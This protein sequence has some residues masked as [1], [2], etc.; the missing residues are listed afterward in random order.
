MVVAY[1]AVL[2][3]SGI[4][5]LAAWGSGGFSSAAGPTAAPVRADVTPFGSTA[6]TA[7]GNLSIPLAQGASTLSAGTHVVATYQFQVVSW[8][9]GLTNLTVWVAS[10][11]VNFPEASGG[12]LTETLPALNETVTSTALSNANATVGN[13]TIGSGG[14]SFASGSTATLSSQLIAVMV[15][16][17]WG[18]VKL[19][20]RWHWES[21]PTA[22]TASYSPWSAYQT[23][24]PPEH[25]IV[26][27]DGP[28]QISPGQSFN[29]CIGGPIQS[30]SFSLHM[31]VAN[32]YYAFAW[33]STHVAANW[34]GPYCWAVLMPKSF[35][36]LPAALLVHLWEYNTYPSILAILHTEGVVFN[37]GTATGK[38]FPTSAKAQLG[39]TALSL[40]AG[41]YN[42]DVAPGTYS[43]TANASGYIA[44]KVSVKVVANKTTWTNLTL[45]PADGT[46]AGTVSPASAQLSI[47]GTALSVDASSGDFSKNLAP[48]TYV[49]HAQATGYAA[50]NCTATIVA[51]ATTTDDLTLTRLT[52]WLAG[53][54]TPTGASVTVDGGSIATGPAG[55]FNITLPTDLYSV[56]ASLA[57]YTVWRANV[58]ILSNVTTTVAI[59]LEPGWVAGSVTPASAS[60]QLD[61]VAVALN[62][63]TGAFNTSQLGGIVW[64]HASA[65]GYLPF[66][67][68]VTVTP[69]QTL[70]LTV[71]LNDTATVEGNLLPTD[72]V[73]RWDDEPVLVNASGNWSET[74]VSGTHWLNATLAGYVPFGENVTLAAGQTRALVIALSDAADVSGVI[75][76]TNAS[77]LWDGQPVNVTG[78][79]AWN[80]T[81]T[82]GSHWLNGSAVGYSPQDLSV[83]LQ[84]GEDAW[85]NLSLVLLTGLIEGAVTPVG[86]NL[87]IDGAAGAV[88]ALGA[89]SFTEV[90]GTYS[91]SASTANHTTVGRSA[92]VIAGN[93]TWVNLTLPWSVGWV[94]GTVLPGNA[95]VT[96][97]D[98]AVVTSAGVFNV[99]LPAGTSEWVASET[100]FLSW[101]GSAVVVAGQSTNLSITL[102]AQPTVATPPVT[103]PPVTVPPGTTP[104]VKVPPLT[105]P[106]TGARPS[107]W[108]GPA[109]L[110]AGVLVG[111]L[112]ALA[113]LVTW[114]GIRRRRRGPSARA[115]PTMDR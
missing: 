99:T 18:T 75:L 47:N 72:A 24:T 79:G 56:V 21:T 59:T 73:L 25:L 13:A 89:F 34:T 86:A 61:G 52:G 67:E 36:Q 43:L 108:Y 88:D 69:G 70:P 19:S 105:P 38:I 71:A 29:V 110:D 65:P 45:A 112:A 91:L 66:D 101:N 44:G 115:A 60:L 32:P 111:I 6:T 37:G 40:T 100:G 48:G 74:T 103:P 87:T 84:A 50:Q 15:S 104:P 113:L 92:T 16:V 55:I 42:V 11:Q 31:E 35:T 93:V 3:I 7:T 57:G 2:L 51:N 68:N 53:T 23:F 78:N 64:V 82:S 77:L 49:V 62:A 83:T 20:F 98:Q 80:L 39:T 26:L 90:P 94:D 76:P 41:V 102:T 8:P 1:R 10:V 33:N 28:A 12:T 58:S 27:S 107:P 5:L 22:G 14:T 9:K 96:V 85:E 106:A 17:S 95:S 97:G 81:T 30:R 46:L 114:V 109:A 54:I 4:L 63:S